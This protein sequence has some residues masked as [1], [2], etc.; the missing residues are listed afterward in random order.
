MFKKILLGG[1]IAGLAGGV[2]GGIIKAFGS[3]KTVIAN[4]EAAQAIAQA[5]IAQNGKMS[6]E[7]KKRLE[8]A[9]R[10]AERYIKAK[11]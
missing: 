8:D 3:K 9:Q 10:A 4:L 6:E 7:S 11:R 5:E 1:F 2:T